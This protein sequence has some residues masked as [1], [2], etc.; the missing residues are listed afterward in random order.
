MRIAVVENS[1]NHDLIHSVIK[2]NKDWHVDYFSCSK[3]LGKTSIH[4]YD[5]VLV[6]DK[7][8]EMQGVRLI[9]ALSEKSPIEFALMSDSGNFSETDINN[10]HISAL[11]EKQNIDKVIDWLKYIDIKIRIN[12]N[13]KIEKEKLNNILSLTNGFILDVKDD[14]A[15]LGFSKPLS[16]KGRTEILEVLTKSKGAIVY[17]SN[18]NKVSSMFLGEIVFLYKEMQKH[19]KQLVFLNNDK[20]IVKFIQACNLDKILEIFETEE[21]ALNY[22]NKSIIVK[23]I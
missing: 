3:E 18:N 23:K 11:I 15:F 5:V 8:P 4:E 16:K 14:I 22:L 19:G 2:E 17:F 21:E 10:R 13:I 12:N 20:N 6:D 9:E 1:Q 7:L